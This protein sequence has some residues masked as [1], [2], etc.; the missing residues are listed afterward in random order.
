M[1][2][3]RAAKCT[4]PQLTYCACPKGPLPPK[5]L[6]PRGSVAPQQLHAGAAQLLRPAQA[7]AQARPGAGAHWPGR[8]QALIRRLVRPCLFFPRDP[9]PPWAPDT[10]GSAKRHRTCCEHLAFQSTIATTLGATTLG[11]GVPKRGTARGCTT[12]SPHKPVYRC[13]SQRRTGSSPTCVPVTRCVSNACSSRT[14]AVACR[15]G[16][17]RFSERSATHCYTRRRCLLPVRPS[18][19]ALAATCRWRR[20]PSHAV[21]E[22]RTT[23]G[24]WRLS[25]RPHWRCGPKYCSV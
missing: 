10:S 1:A 24:A 25:A 5:R 16:R 8:A 2:S 23:C 9:N 13:D 11:A 7:P 12:P 20:T 19:D 3:R 18:S 15:D 6:A 4:A 21:Q 22:P 14:A 17:M